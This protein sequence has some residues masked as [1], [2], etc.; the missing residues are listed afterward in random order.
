MTRPSFRSRSFDLSSGDA[1]PGLSKAAKLLFRAWALSRRLCS[2]L[3]YCL[4]NIPL[5]SFHLLQH[6]WSYVPAGI[7]D[8][9][10][11]VKHKCC[12]CTWSIFSRIQ[13]KGPSGS[14]HEPTRLRLHPRT[15]SLRHCPTFDGGY[16]GFMSVNVCGHAQK[17]VR[18]RRM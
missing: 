18:L 12:S 6:L 14:T 4:A 2:A 13:S 16:G 7:F 10:K 3:L 9:R 8:I 17:K 1:R 11:S 5:P 15:H